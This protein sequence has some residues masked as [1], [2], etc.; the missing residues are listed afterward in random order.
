VRTVN[1]PSG[2]YFCHLEAEDFR[3]IRRFIATG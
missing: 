1:L 2:L 3:A